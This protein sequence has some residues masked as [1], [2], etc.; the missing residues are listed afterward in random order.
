MKRVAAAVLPLHG[1]HAP[2]WLV[3]RMK[4]LAAEIVTVIVDEYGRDQLLLRLSDPFWFQSLGCVLGY[5]WHSSGVT[6]VLTGVLREAFDPASVGVALCGG[7][8]RRSNM[9]PAEIHQYGSRFKL[10]EE[11]IGRLEYSSRLTAKVDSAAIQ[12]GYPLY[13]HAFFMTVDGKWAV[14]QQGMDARDKTARRYHWVSEHV[15]SLVVEPHDAIVGDTVRPTALDMTSRNSEQ[16]RKVAVDLVKDGVGKLRNDFLSLRSDNQRVLTEW[17]NQSP[18]PTYTSQV[19]RMPRHIDWDAMRRAY[20]F[21]PAEYEELLSVQGIGPGAVRALAL[22]SQ[23]IYGAKPSWQDPVKFSFA[24]GGKDGV[25]FPV[26]RS[27]YDETIQHLSQLIE[28]ARLEGREKYAALKRLK[29][30]A[31]A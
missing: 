25:P 18:N 17:M 23:I 28:K 14:I 8:G 5:D 22:V 26:D 15:Q 1:G 2:G 11:Q 13:H 27:S 7:K 3:S 30:I 10:S 12:A 19:L 6:T 29:A 21:Q 9:A 31:P 16:S 20:E 24:L 4:H